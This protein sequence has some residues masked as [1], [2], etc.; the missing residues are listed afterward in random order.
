MAKK[1]KK[2]N[3][4]ISFG[5]KGIIKPKNIRKTLNRLLVELKADRLKIYIAILLSFVSAIVV[6]FGPKI[7]GRIINTIYEGIVRRL[8]GGEGIDFKAILHWSIF[9]GGIYLTNFVLMYSQGMLLIRAA[10]RVTKRLRTKTHEKIMKLPL[11]YFDQTTHGDIMSRIANDIDALFYILSEAL[12]GIIRNVAMVVGALVMMFTISWKLTLVALIMLPVSTVVV[13]LIISKSQRFF[14][15]QRALIG[16]VNGRVEEDYSGHQ[17]IKAFGV[18]DTFYERFHIQNDELKNASWKAQFISS[19]TMPLVTIIGHLGYI[20]VCIYGGAL[21]IAGAITVGDISA[22]IQYIRLFTDPIA[23][24][25]SLTGKVQTGLAAC[26]RVFQLIDEQEEFDAVIGSPLQHVKGE[27]EFDHVTFGYDPEKPIIKDFSLKVLPGQKV[28]IVGPTGAGK[29]TLVKLL[30]RFYDLQAGKIRLDGQDISQ[31]QR[32]DVRSKFGMVLQDTWLYNASIRDNIRYGTLSASEQE[33]KAAAKMA[34]VDSFVRMLPH[35]YDFMLSEDSGNLSAGQ[36]QLLTIARA[37]LADHDM[38]ILDEAT[39]SVDTRT[40]FEIQ[41][42]MNLLM[43]GKTSFVIAHRL[44]TIKDA[45]VILVV[46][47]GNIVEQGNHYELLQRQ[48]HYASLYNA[49]FEGQ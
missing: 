28:A 39:S 25:A 42:A 21:A 11:S 22:F 26:E 19:I 24:I 31:F 45:D 29:T 8:Q 10:N 20:A 37:F 9:L 36:K 34:H 46:E 2:Q 33:I 3:I 18:E 23:Q 27:I 44:S 48:G 17:V 40:E 47:N 30:M 13:L 14:K 6:I 35:S 49:Q 5:Q 1:D 4:N 12:A 15:H 38:M 16:E 41:E 7:F 43:E 32:S